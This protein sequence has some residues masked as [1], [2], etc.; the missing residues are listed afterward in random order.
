MATQQELLEQLVQ[1]TQA[2]KDLAERPDGDRPPVISPIAE[3]TEAD[4]VRQRVAFGYAALGALTG[5]VSSASGREFDIRVFTAARDY[6]VIFLDG[7]PR[8][9][10]FI[11]LRRG[12]KVEL[13]RI[14][15]GVD[16][17]GHTPEDRRVELNDERDGVA[18]DRGAIFPEQFGNDEAIGS[19]LALRTRRGPLLAFGP[20][21][22]PLPADRRTS[23]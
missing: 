5:R 11:E 10:R 7:L 4:R 12:G 23:A 21:L 1:L 22:S 20:R 13:L 14:F 17:D 15:V 3:I 2:V 9:A 8:R 18:S 19:M 16:V 6:G